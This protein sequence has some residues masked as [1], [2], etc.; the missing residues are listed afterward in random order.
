LGLAGILALAIFLLGPATAS[1]IFPPVYHNP[2]P[3][4]PT[5][6]VGQTEPPVTVIGQPVTPPVTPPVHKTPEPATLITGLIGLLGGGY[7]LRR[8]KN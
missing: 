4:P 2:T 6:T 3:P 7:I 5:T 1:A 8:K